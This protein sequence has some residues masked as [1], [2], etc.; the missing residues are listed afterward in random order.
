MNLFFFYKWLVSFIGQQ[1]RKNNFDLPVCVIK[2]STCQF[3]AATRVI[4][5]V[6]L[7]LID[8]ILSNPVAAEHIFLSAQW[9][10]V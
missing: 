3:S 9:N 5:K 8:I 4:N 6:S 7:I 1:F 10:L 2:K